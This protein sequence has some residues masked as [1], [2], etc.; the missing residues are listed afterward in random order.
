MYLQIKVLTD[1]GCFCVFSFSK[2]MVNRF[3]ILTFAK[4]CF[5]KN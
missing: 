3:Q 1:L 5:K 2:A 4:Y